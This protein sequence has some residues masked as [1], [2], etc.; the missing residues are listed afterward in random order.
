MENIASAND[1]ALWLMPSISFDDTIS[2]NMSDMSD[3]IGV[4]NASSNSKYI[5]EYFVK[6]FN[7]PKHALS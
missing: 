1:S 3:K 6:Y 7:D 4:R 2:C 5:R